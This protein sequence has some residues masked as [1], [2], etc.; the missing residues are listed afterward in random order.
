M[1]V[2]YLLENEG[3]EVQF[4][5]KGKVTDYKFIDNNIIEIKLS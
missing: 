3:L 5:G 1:D 4:I 2:I